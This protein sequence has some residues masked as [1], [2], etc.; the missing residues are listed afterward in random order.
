MSRSIPSFLRQFAPPASDAGLFL[1]LLALAAWLD[2]ERAPE[3]TLADRSPPSR[4][5]PAARLQPLTGLQPPQ[6]PAAPA[7]AQPA[8]AQSP[9]SPPQ[10]EPAPSQEKSQSDQEQPAPRARFRPFEGNYAASLT[11]AII[12]L[13]PFIVVTTA[14]AMFTHHVAQDVHASR[15]ALSII[16]GLSTAGY[17]FGALLGGDLVQRFPQR[18]LF[19]LDET[20]FVLGCVLAAIAHGPALY[21]AGRVVQGFAT[22]QLL[23]TAL[24]PVI[25][26]FP[27]SK[28]PITVIAINIGF[29]G[30]VCIGP[31]LGGWVAAGHHWRWFY[32]ALGAIGLINLALA[33]LTLPDQPP[34]NPDMR[35]DRLGIPLAFAAVVLPF[36]ASGELAG[37]GFASARF[38]APMFVGLVCF[39]AMLLVEYHQKEPLA[40][41]KKMWTTQS[42]TGALVAMIGGGVFVSF[43]E[44]G[45]RYHM[46]VA[47]QSPLAT[48][49]LFWPLAPAVLISAALLGAVIT[50]RYLTLL[51][52]A[53]MVCMM[54]SGALL[55]QLSPHASDALTLS[56]A[57][58]LGVG[59]GATV[60]PG[61]YLAGFS[62]SAKLIGRVF[63]LVEL[64]R[65]VADYILAPVMTQIARAA[66]G[67][68]LSQHG[69]HLALGITLWITVAFTVLGAAL[70]LL[71]GGRL[72]KPDLEGWLSA[73]GPAIQPTPLL[74]RLR[75]H[76]P[77]VGQ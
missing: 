52:V 44:L 39:V 34:F 49:I 70:Y 20:A 10:A 59:A 48:G 4:L 71:G 35:F 30:A 41:I 27:A 23:V 2:A 57:G 58:L 21:A 61:L 73:K 15:N 13:S 29:F 25:Q 76:Q 3:P 50:T 33:T 45:E 67:Q 40:P 17:A 60:A 72:S 22:G 11:S 56:A 43:L 7:G 37:H 12:A 8:P 28:L 31:L 63:A 18:R 51:I 24:P 74:S 64:V 62:L 38:A 1:G 46:E 47:H 32:G 66:S 75:K 68:H 36:W 14:Y 69:V 53:G 54:G 42:V 9:A 65:S 16:G 6:A 26:R 55:L 5:P 19:F 77:D